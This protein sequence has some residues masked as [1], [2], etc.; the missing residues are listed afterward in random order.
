MITREQAKEILRALNTL[1]PEKVTE[2]QDFVF[3]LKG[4]YGGEKVIEESDAWTEEDLHDLT[5]AVLQ[6][7][8]QIV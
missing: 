8:D 5:T 6:H 2:V 3:F 1:P 7:A 4:R